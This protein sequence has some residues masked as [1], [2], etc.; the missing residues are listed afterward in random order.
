MKRKEFKLYRCEECNKYVNEHE[1]LVAKSP[2]DEYSIITG[3]PHCKVAVGDGGWLEICEVEGCNKQATCGIPVPNEDYLR[4]CG[5]HMR[6]AEVL[7]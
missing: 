4:C 5:N 2:F 3:C 6:E 7:K 1:M